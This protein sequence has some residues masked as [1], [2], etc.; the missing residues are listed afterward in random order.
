MR[1]GG[2]RS[3]QGLTGLAGEAFACMHRAACHTPLD[4]SSLSHPCLQAGGLA[5]PD[6][7]CPTA[8]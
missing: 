4:D 1:G 6:Q 2:I 3:V 7:R 5:L 8:T